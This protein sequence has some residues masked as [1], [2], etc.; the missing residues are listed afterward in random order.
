[1][2]SAGGMEQH[3][4]RVEHGSTGAGGHE[5]DRERQRADRCAVR[6]VEEAHLVAIAEKT[7]RHAGVTQEAIELGRRRVI[8]ATGDGLARIE[9]QRW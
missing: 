8:P 2:S 3:D 6:C 5:P 1:M 9:L 7:D 4:K